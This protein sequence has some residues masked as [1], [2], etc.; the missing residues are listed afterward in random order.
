MQCEIPYGQIAIMTDR[1][2]WES[3]TAELH[4]DGKIDEYLRKRLMPLE[5]AMD[6]RLEMYGNSVA[7]RTVGEDLF[8]YINFQ[9]RYD[10][11]ARIERALRLSREFI[12]PLPP[13]AVPR[14]AVDDHI[15][16]RQDSCCF[17]GR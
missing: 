10:I 7:V 4:A 6:T 9:R 1:P 3:S 13:G 2:W 12:E 8:E 17:D 15:E 11:D 16:C 5:G 14:D